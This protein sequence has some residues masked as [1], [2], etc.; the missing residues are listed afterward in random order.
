LTASLTHPYLVQ[1]AQ[2]AAPID[3]VCEL[4][5]RA[6]KENPP[7]VIRDGGVIAEGYNEELVQ[8][9]NLADGAPEY[10]EKLEADE[11]ER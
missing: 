6:I 9:R 4:L 2:F 1:L 7:V 3:E 8:W 11:R 10:L 5:E